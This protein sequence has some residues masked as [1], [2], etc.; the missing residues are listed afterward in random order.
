MTILS[1]TFITL[2]TFKWSLPIVYSLAT[3]NNSSI[4]KTFMTLVTFKWFLHRCVELC[5]LKTYK[6]TILC[7]TFITLITFKRSLPCV[8]SS[9][10]QWY[11]FLRKKIPHQSHLNGFSPLCVLWCFARLLFWAKL[12]SHLSNLNYFS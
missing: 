11:F 2:I 12:V 3:Y 7:I 8:F 5:S 1:I 6:M 10:I 4:S 9:D